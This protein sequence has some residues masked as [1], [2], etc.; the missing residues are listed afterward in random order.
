MADKEQELAS[1]VAKIELLE[2]IS[3]LSPD[4]PI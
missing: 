3:V 4:L 1:L 2:E